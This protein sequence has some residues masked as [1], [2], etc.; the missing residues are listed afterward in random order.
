MFDM[1]TTEI[2][3]FEKSSLNFLDIFGPVEKLQHA[4]EILEVLWTLI[5]LL[6]L[7]QRGHDFLTKLYELSTKLIPAFYEK[8]LGTTDKLCVL[9]SELRRCPKFEEF[10]KRSEDWAEVQR[11][12]L[13]LRELAWSSRSLLETRRTRMQLRGLFWSA[14]I[15]AEVPGTCR[16]DEEVI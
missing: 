14:R 11:V 7:L 1:C 8:L 16:I 9:L 4:T 3:S 2:G 15:L 5:F 13:K 10:D 12:Y 6:S